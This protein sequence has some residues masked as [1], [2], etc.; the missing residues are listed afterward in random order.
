MQVLKS[1]IA[2]AW[3]TGQGKQQELVNPTTE[4][5]V[6]TVCADGLD[7]QG[8]LDFARQRGGAALRAMTIG[9]RGELLAAM[10]KAIHN[11][12]GELLA[13]A[14]E[15][16]GNTR[17]D[18]KF[19]V[20]GASGT[21]AAYAELAKEKAEQRFLIDG[22]DSQIGLSPRLVGRH[23]YVPRRGVALLINAYNFPAWGFAEKAACAILAG[24]PVVCKPATST[25]WVA[26]RMIELIAPLV[27]EGVVSLVCG[28]A[29]SM[30][31]M[32]DYGDLISFTGSSDTALR[33]RKLEK[34]QNSAVRLNVEADSLNAAVL[35]EKVDDDTYD[36]F[37]RDVVRELTQKAGQKCTATRRIF[38]H[39]SHLDNL[40]DD[41]VERITAVRM[42]DP[43]LDGIKLGP[44]ATA[45]QKRD[46]LAGIG[47]LSEVA[48]K[49]CGNEAPSP[50]GVADNT[51][52]F[53]PATLL[54]APDASADA[55]H[56]HEV[57][58][59]VAT[60]MRTP[61]D[62]D[63]LCQLV[64]R[65]RGGLVCSVYSDDRKFAGAML[66]GL[67]P[68]HGRLVFGSKKVAGKAL[69]PGM[70]LPNLLHGGP[71]RAGG[72]EELGGWR[73]VALYSQR[74]ALQ[75]D[76]ALLDAILAG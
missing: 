50:A 11:A 8:G 34:V 42:G 53:V 71:G 10:A 23:V 69:S 27:P 70:V 6:A 9:E 63:A 44:L 67:A 38:V 24:M 1:Y 64:A 72:G 19:D 61:E 47:R 59:P 57:F 28:S 48:E 37:L 41:L 51:G 18:A 68:H 73:G 54:L 22:D 75:G 12:R 3:V 7:L 13:I 60:M 29:H 31:A 40:R 20:D 65:G 43:S 5:I 62:T 26:Q 49:L 45:Q 39:E 14:T 56:D 17:S 74:T 33:L 4:A 66:A 16:G 30:P 32:L 21:L 35:G 58:G 46:V 2:G 52:Y 76:R 36:V 15:N 25:A 55:I